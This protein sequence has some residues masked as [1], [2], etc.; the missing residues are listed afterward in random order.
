MD[1]RSGACSH[2][3][4]IPLCCLER[5]PFG[6]VTLNKKK[7]IP[8]IIACSLF[9]VV[10]ILF[11]VTFRY[12]KSGVYNLPNTSTY[13]SAAKAVAVLKLDPR[14]AK[15]CRTLAENA[16][17]KRDYATS[18]QEWDKV[19]QV[20]PDNRAAKLSRAN[21]LSFNGQTNRAVTDLTQLAQNNDAF[22]VAAKQMLDNIKHRALL[23]K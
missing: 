4:T 7:K 13:S 15:A 23:Q 10:A 17:N 14:D 6:I 5:K 19:L 3:F 1:G 2:A 8:I 21:A 12:Y 22:G 9:F 20:E 11:I 16:F 18:V